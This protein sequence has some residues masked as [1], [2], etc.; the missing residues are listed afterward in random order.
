VADRDAQHRARLDA[1]GERR[2]L[3]LGAQM[4]IAADIAQTGVAHQRPGQ[5]TA[6]VRIWKPLQMPNTRP[7]RSANCFTAPMIGEK[8]AIAPQRR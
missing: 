2:V 5:Q 3:A 8:R 6:S 7:P 4:D 1:G